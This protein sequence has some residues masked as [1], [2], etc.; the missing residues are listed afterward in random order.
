[1]RFRRIYGLTFVS[2]LALMIG[3]AVIDASAA[4]SCRIN[5]ATI[6]AGYDDTVVDQRLEPEIGEL[7]AIFKYT[8]YRLLGSEALNLDIEKTGEL[9]L[10]GKHELSIALKGLRKDRAELDI[11]LSKQSNTVFQTTIQLLNKGNL[12]VGGP[13][14]LNGNLIFKISSSF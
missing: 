3:V 6:L 9:A 11:H 4:E 12:F 1:M 10:P 8:S 14:Y 2:I 13:K 7:Q 5:V